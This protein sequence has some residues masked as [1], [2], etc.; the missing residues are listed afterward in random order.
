MSRKAFHIQIIRMLKYI[1][2]VHETDTF[3]NGGCW[4][5]ESPRSPRLLRGGEVIIAISIKTWS[6]VK[7]EAA[8]L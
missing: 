1:R 6:D 7:F 3:I 5:G 4:R 2:R 8:S